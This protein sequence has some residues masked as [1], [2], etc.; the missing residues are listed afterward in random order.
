M[1]IKISRLEG[2]ESSNVAI[3]DKYESKKHSVYDALARLTKNYNKAKHKNIAMNNDYCITPLTR[4]IN[5]E[6]I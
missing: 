6:N 1:K 3:I 4:K 5:C 2:V